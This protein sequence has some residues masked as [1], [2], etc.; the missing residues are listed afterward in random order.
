MKEEDRKA[1]N[2]QPVPFRPL[3]LAWGLGFR[4][5]IPLIVFALLGRLIDR[6]VNTSPLFLFAGIILSIVVSTLMVYREA[7][8][9]LQEID[10]GSKR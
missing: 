2:P 3:Q 8:K 4:I 7:R 5:A 1:N 10:N 6:M 9:F